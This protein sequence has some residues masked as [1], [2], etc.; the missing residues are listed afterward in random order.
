M[1]C[2]VRESAGWRL[3]GDDGVPI[4]LHDWPRTLWLYR[5]GWQPVPGTGLWLPLEEPMPAPAEDPGLLP[6]A[7]VALSVVWISFMIDLQITV[8]DQA[9][10]VQIDDLEDSLLLWVRWAVLLE[11]GGYPHA[12]LASSLLT[13]LE[14]HPDPTPGPTPDPA[15]CCLVLRQHGQ[16]GPVRVRTD[17]AALVQA[18]RGLFRALADHPCLGP[19]FLFCMESDEEAFTLASDAADAAYARAVAAGEVAADW[20]CEVDFT[21]RFCAAALPLSP[22]QRHSLRRWQAMLRQMALPADWQTDPHWQSPRGELTINR[23]M[24]R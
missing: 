15:L 1:L 13:V 18:F 3:S 5:S 21:S 2:C 10:R 22:G 19:G 8:G 4:G 24:D 17:R 16:P 14:V 7:G 12:V 6:V 20:D 11:Q 23:E 9:F